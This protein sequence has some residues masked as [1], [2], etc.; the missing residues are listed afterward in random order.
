M[1]VDVSAKLTVALFLIGLVLFI[2]FLISWPVMMLWNGCL[3]GAIDSVK[4]IGWLQSWG[5]SILFGLLFKSTPTTKG[6]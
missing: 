2:S 4:E 5:I 1:N 3:V 6:N